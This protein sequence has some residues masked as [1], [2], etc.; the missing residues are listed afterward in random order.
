MST[1]TMARLTST[2]LIPGPAVGRHPAVDRL[3]RAC[4]CGQAL[5]AC[6]TAHCPRCGVRL[7]AP[8]RTAGAR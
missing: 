4:G 5:D 6:H 8:H 3:A 7:A 1:T 2:P